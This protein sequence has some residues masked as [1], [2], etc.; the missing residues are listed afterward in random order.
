MKVGYLR[1]IVPSALTF[2]FGLLAEGTPV[3][4]AE[5]EME[6]LPAEGRCRSC[7]VESRLG[8]FR[9]EMGEQTTVDIGSP[10]RFGLWSHSSLSEPPTFGLWCR[11]WSS[12]LPSPPICQTL[13]RL[14]PDNDPDVPGAS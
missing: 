11:G 7:G 4:G 1:Q 12:A 9:C 14:Y 13:P 8:S 2:G 3:E 6:Q 10:I 5:L